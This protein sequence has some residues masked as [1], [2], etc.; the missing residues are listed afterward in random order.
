MEKKILE[1]QRKKK[2]GSTFFFFRNCWLKKFELAWALGE[3]L[4][5]L[6]TSSLKWTLWGFYI[7]YI[8]SFPLHFVVVFVCCKCV[9]CL[10]CPEK[11]GSSS[12][13]FFFLD[14]EFFFWSW[15]RN[16]LFRFNM[17][18]KEVF[19]FWCLRHSPQKL[20]NW[21]DFLLFFFSVWLIFCLHF[22]FLCI[23]FSLLFL[24]SS[25]WNMQTVWVF[26][27]CLRKFH[28]QKMKNVFFFR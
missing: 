6:K 16:N 23:F 28:F 27:F 25:R 22:F 15:M 20:G 5:L 8:K 2:K 3:T 4:H 26:S 13:S 17:S 11:F 18:K 19:S 24:Y 21:V 10:N 9:W 1:E 12:T 14:E 7:E